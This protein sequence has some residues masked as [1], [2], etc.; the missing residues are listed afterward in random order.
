[1]EQGFLERE[2]KR[3]NRKNQKM[4]LILLLVFVALF[5][6]IGF[7]V[8]EEIDLNDYRTKKIVIYAALLVGLM[9]V[10]AV[11]MLFLSSRAAADGSKSLR[12]L[13]P[14]RTREETA[15][16]IDR[17]VAEGQILVDEYTAEFPEGKAPRGE[18][19]MLLPSY[20]L[21]RNS[22]GQILA[23]PREKI[24]WICAQ[25]GRKG[26]SSFIVR[27]LIFTEQKVFYVEGAD[28]AHMQKIAD[29][30]YQYIPNVFRAYDP[31]VLSYE[32][33]TLFDRD[34][35]AFMQFYEKEK[36]NFTAG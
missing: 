22:L 25:A 15:A 34:R 21:Y 20:L 11:L 24:Y 27:L 7:M 4:I 2:A 26:R 9:L 29:K 3:A 1:M 17:E 13:F 10:S 36:N 12:F 18:R 30:L 19:V 8:R 35:A 31:F 28:V 6:F 23:I 32:L 14:G 33:E 5:T 16:I